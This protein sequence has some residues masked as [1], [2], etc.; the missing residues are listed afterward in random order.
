METNEKQIVKK[1]WELV[2]VIT[3]DTSTDDKGVML[4]VRIQKLPLFRPRYSMEVGALRPDG[5]FM[6]HL[7]PPTNVTNAVV[8]MSSVAG[9]VETL[10][11]K[12]ETWIYGNLQDR[13]DQIILKQQSQEN[14]EL[15]RNVKGTPHTGKTAR[16][17][18]QQKTTN[19]ASH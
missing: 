11:A 13:E 7:Q 14:K 1:Q 10:L 6:R 19:G 2:K 4:C 17:R 5:V 8:N 3:D 16:K 18:E 12:A 9:R 15:S